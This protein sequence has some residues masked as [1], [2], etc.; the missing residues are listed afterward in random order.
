MS[1]QTVE[2]NDGSVFTPEFLI[3]RVVPSVT[4]EALASTIAKT[5]DE[6][7][8]AIKQ[9]R[10]EFRRI[11][12]DGGNTRM[13]QDA[14]ANLRKATTEFD[15]ELEKRENDVQAT[16]ARAEAQLLDRTA[17]LKLPAGLDREDVRDQE[18]DLRARFRSMDPLDRKVQYLEAA[19]RGDTLVL[20][21]VENVHEL[22]RIVD[23]ETIQEGAE[24]FAA[25]T[26][27]DAYN[28]LEQ[29]RATK[30][31]LGWARAAFNKNIR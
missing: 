26:R 19:K 13:A 24:L 11:E 18:M 12:R 23:A 10:A 15:A 2:L 25:A 5:A 1:T 8:A 31:A 17:R 6:A 22:A 27:P 16:I 30:M 9:H 14:I 21:A 4:D 29:Q 20:R 7:E 28:L 3:N